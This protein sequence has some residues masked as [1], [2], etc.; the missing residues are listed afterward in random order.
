MDDI[1]G[2]LHKMGKSKD[3][4]SKSVQLKENN[5]FIVWSVTFWLR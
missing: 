4:I 3:F 2:T 5:S 1:L